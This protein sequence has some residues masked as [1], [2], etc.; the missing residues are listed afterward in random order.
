MIHCLFQEMEGYVVANLRL[1]HFVVD[2]NMLFL[3]ICLVFLLLFPEKHHDQTMISMNCC[4]YF[5]NAD[6]FYDL[7]GK[8]NGEFLW[9]HHAKDIES[10]V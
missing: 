6:A 4:Y 1:F 8:K 2:L 5:H 10:E 7:E 3:I 9:S